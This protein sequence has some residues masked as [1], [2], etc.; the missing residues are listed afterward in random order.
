MHC[1]ILPC[2]VPRA[3]EDKARRKPATRPSSESSCLAS[4]TGEC[5]GARCTVLT[6]EQDWDQSYF[7]VSFSV[8]VPEAGEVKVRLEPLSQTTFPPPSFLMYLYS[9]D[10]E[11][12]RLSAT[13]H[14][15]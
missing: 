8:A 5:S 11:P 7:Q 13:L 10:V 15:G 14:V 1:H 12:G 4:D 3:K 6:P 9:K 2:P